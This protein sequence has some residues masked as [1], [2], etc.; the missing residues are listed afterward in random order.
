MNITLATAVGYYW[1]GG[2]KEV[3][4]IEV[5]VFSEAKNHD[6]NM[7]S[8]CQQKVEQWFR[9]TFPNVRLITLYCDNCPT[10]FRTNKFIS[11]VADRTK[12][13]KVSRN[14]VFF[15]R[16]HGKT[17]GDSA[18]GSLKRWLDKQ[19]TLAEIRKLEDICFLIKSNKYKKTK[20]SYK[21][22]TRK[23]LWIPKH[24]AMHM[25]VT[26]ERRVDNLRD[27]FEYRFRYNHLTEDIDSNRRYLSCVCAHCSAL[28]FDHCENQHVGGLHPCHWLAM[29]FN[30]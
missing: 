25:P 13:D 15:G 2:S 18:G 11:N 30:E 12:E 20:G 17:V 23:A 3:E 26:T 14:L 5:F 21:V 1:D 22:T 29:F 24:L 27:F 10:H 7:T 9:E 19:S 4:K 6:S 8:R 16:Y 28:D